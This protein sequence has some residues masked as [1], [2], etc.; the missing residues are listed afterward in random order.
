MKTIVL[1]LLFVSSLLGK[2]TL[3]L[4]EDTQMQRLTTPI[5]F[6]VGQPDVLFVAPKYLLLQQAISNSCKYPPFSVEGAYMYNQKKYWKVKGYTA[7]YDGNPRISTKQ[8]DLERW[9]LLQEPS[10]IPNDGPVSTENMHDSAEAS[11]WI[12]RWCFFSVSKER[13]HASI[14][15]AGVTVKSGSFVFLFVNTADGVCPVD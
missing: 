5:Q 11:I 8:S 12:F 7:F 9:N 2:E 3:Q 13:F 4:S 6:C 10:P 14:Y 1:L 15:T